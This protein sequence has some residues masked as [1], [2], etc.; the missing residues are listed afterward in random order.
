MFG[1]DIR[2]GIP[3]LLGIQLVETYML[4]FTMV[5]WKVGLICFRRSRRILREMKLCRKRRGYNAG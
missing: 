3:D 1:V 5:G 4:H 2:N